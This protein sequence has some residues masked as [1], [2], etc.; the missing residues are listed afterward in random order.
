MKLSLIETLL[1][2]AK[3]AIGSKQYQHLYVT[4]YKKRDIVEGGKISCAYFLS[5]ILHNLELIRTAH[6][7]VEST[8]EDMV[9]SGWREITEPKPGSILLWEKNKNGHRHIGVYTKKKRAIS[10]SEKKLTPVEHDWHFGG[11][12][13]KTYRQIEKIFWHDALN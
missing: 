12:G 7:T 5:S 6:A 3:G 1:A 10:N 11:E 9:K 13:S 8:I 2:Q 4:N